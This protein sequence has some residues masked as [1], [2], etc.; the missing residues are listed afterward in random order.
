MVHQNL[1]FCHPLA[2]E[3][4]VLKI[5]SSSSCASAAVGRIHPLLLLVPLSG[6]TSGGTEGAEAL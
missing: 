6:C 5:L 3:D 2:W 1:S 4:K